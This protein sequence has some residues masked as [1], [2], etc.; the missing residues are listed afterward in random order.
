MNESK[1]I[2]CGR[3]IT[4][5]TSSER[6]IS[7]Y[8]CEICGDV[9]ITPEARSSI[10]SQYSNIKYLFSGYIRYR[11]EYKLGPIEILSNNIEYIINSSNIP[12]NIPEKLDRILL[13][14]E[15]KTEFAGQSVKINYNTDYPIA[16]ARNFDEFNFLILQL[17]ALGFIENE[18]TTS[19]VITLNGWT[20]LYELKQYKIDSN[21]AFIAMWFSEEMIKPFNNGFN[22]AI[23]DCGYQPI[24]IDLLEHNDKICDAIIAE[25][26]MSR[27]MVADFTNHRQNV[28]FEA[29]FAMGIGIPVIYTCHNDFMSNEQVH[30]DTRQYNHIIWNDE[31]DL[32][33]KLYNRIKATIY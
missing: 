16:F 15:L 4:D 13:Y 8:R 9:R 1:C 30:F 20:R 19:F 12:S 31:R 33:D 29:G 32:Y 7:I 3:D 10:N 18:S 21:K 22:Q 17:K 26:K 25:I 6:E 2:F 23:S 27:F 24:K 28:Y 5:F 11:T 14:L